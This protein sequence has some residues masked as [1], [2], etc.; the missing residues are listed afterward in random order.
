MVNVFFFFF[1]VFTD[2]WVKSIIN[3][4]LEIICNWMGNFREGQKGKIQIIVKLR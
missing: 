1:K 4:Y 3:G 2:L